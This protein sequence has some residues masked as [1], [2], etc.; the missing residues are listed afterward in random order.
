LGFIRDVGRAADLSE[1]AAHADLNPKQ[2]VA[3][4]DSLEG[5]E[6]VLQY[7]P[8]PKRLTRGGLRHSASM[9]D[10][11]RPEAQDAYLGLS[12]LLLGV[13]ADG[14]D[15]RE[16]GKMAGRLVGKEACSSGSN[17]SADALVHIEAFLQSRGFAP[18]QI[19]SSPGAGFVLRCCPFEEAA[20]ANPS[21]V[22]GL[23]RALA[24]GMLEALGGAFEVTKLVARHPTT[25]GCRLEL[26]AIGQPD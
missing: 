18:E 21:L 7:R 13:L 24:Q 11:E 3:D 9:A 20:L 4:V 5:G 17:A 14:H 8:E 15:P 22:C 25:A 16:A 2:V 23:H 6:L 12:E 10:A 26:R 1:I 19:G